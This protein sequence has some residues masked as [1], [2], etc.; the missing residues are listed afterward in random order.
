[1][2]DPII[3]VT[4]NT[5]F[6]PIIDVTLTNE[7]ATVVDVSVNEPNYPAVNVSVSSPTTS[8]IPVTVSNVSGPTIN[9]DVLDP[10]G[11]ASNPIGSI[12]MYAGSTA[13]SGYLIC[14]GSAVSRATYAGLFVVIGTDFGN[15]NGI[16]TF[17]LPD[18]CGRSPIGSGS[19]AGLTTRVKATKF[20][21]ETHLL[22]GAESG[23]S[24]HT[25]LQN[26]HNH[27]QAGHTHVQAAHTHT[28]DAHTHTQDA[29]THIQ[30]QH[31]H[32]VTD[33]GHIHLQT[34]VATNGGASA[35][36]RSDYTTDTAT[37]NILPQT[38][39]NT[40][41]SVTSITVNNATAVNQSTTATN[42]STTATNQTTIATN[43]TT[44]ATNV[45]NT[46]VNQ[47]T[48]PTDAVSAHNN[49]QPS[50]VINFIIKF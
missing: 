34:I 38:G 46:A 16:S 27:F 1:M 49:M 36:T 4:V 41:S 15:G 30:N 21:A 37:A 28:Q 47:A 19:G 50:L 8:V 24:A 42:Q 48:T 14:D 39:V 31:S 26:Q 5:P 29:H 35:V 6:S 2:T 23:T 22:T 18:Y 32:G 11:N 33:P 44:F 40:A 25:H 17:N 7:E 3:N 9:V 10:Y 43:N 13:P 45:A 20:G 12:L